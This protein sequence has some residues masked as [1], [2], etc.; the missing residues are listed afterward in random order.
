MVTATYDREHLPFVSL[1]VLGTETVAFDTGFDPDSLDKEYFYELN[2]RY[3]LNPAIR[4][5]VALRFG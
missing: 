5:E 4:I 1:A 2:M 3:N